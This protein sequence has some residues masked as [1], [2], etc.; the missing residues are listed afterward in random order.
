MKRRY[1]CPW[2]KFSGK[3]EWQTM[4]LV[5]PD[6]D[7]NVSAV[8]DAATDD[9]LRCS[10]RFYFAFHSRMYVHSRIYIFMYTFV[11]CHFSILNVHRQYIGPSTRARVVIKVKQYR[12]RKATDNRFQILLTWLEH[13][14]TCHYIAT[15][16]LAYI[17]LLPWST[18]SSFSYIRWPIS[19]VSRY[20]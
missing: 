20:K 8:S 19:I 6:Y 11:V 15:I 18:P 14:Y 9:C 1:H 5:W 13:Y 16:S 2:W 12:I 7:N 10:L 17:Y 4:D 3:I